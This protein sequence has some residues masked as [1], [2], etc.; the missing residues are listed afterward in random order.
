[1][2]PFLAKILSTGENRIHPSH[3]YSLLQTVAMMTVLFYTVYIEKNMKT[4]L[5]NNIEKEIS[6]QLAGNPKYNEL[7]PQIRKE[8]LNSNFNA[9]LQL[10]DNKTL[11]Q[12]KIAS[13][14]DN[15]NEGQ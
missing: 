6:R 1:M 13:M 11:L 4:E 15:E 2:E 7:F 8:L 10:L 12:N 3:L 5:K 14:T 9:Q